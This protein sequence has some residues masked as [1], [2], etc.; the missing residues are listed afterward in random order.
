[1]VAPAAAIAVVWTN[2]RRLMPSCFINTLSALQLVCVRGHLG[3]VRLGLGRDIA[4]R[5]GDSSQRD[6][7]KERVRPHILA[8]SKGRIENPAFPVAA[9][10]GVWIIR[11]LV[12]VALHQL[13]LL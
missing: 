8:M 3:D 13:G 1:A 2:C 5:P 4:Q 12:A 10:P 7:L 11:A 9:G 6:G